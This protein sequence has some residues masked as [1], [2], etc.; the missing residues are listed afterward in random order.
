MN[1]YDTLDSFLAI[2]WLVQETLVDPG[3][4]ARIAYESLHDGA[5]HGLR[6]R[7]R[8]SRRAGICQWA[9]TSPGSSPA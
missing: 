5:G 8:S 9:S 1:R 4:W 6:Y 7:R 3:G 2:F